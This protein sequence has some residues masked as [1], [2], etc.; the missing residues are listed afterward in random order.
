M[1]AQNITLLADPDGTENSS[2][3]G[4]TAG[5]E[6][7]RGTTPQFFD[8]D[9]SNRPNKA[10]D[11]VVYELT[12]SHKHTA[13]ALDALSRQVRPSMRQSINQSINQST[14][15]S[16]HTQLLKQLHVHVTD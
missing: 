13:E 15:Q 1:Q 8:F 9:K 3:G 11:V 4:K 2:G 7:D 14:S 12:G 10:Y 16:I 5:N 6:E